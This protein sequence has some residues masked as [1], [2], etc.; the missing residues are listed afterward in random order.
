MNSI[1]SI[2]FRRFKKKTLLL[3]RKV[4]SNCLDI[5]NNLC[6]IR[7]KKLFQCISQVYL[8][9]DS[10]INILTGNIGIVVTIIKL[11]P[12]QIATGS[13]DSSIRLWNLQT[14]NCY[15]ELLGHTTIVQCI[16]KL[17]S[18]QIASGSCTIRI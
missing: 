14:G 3:I 7:N 8:T 16:I 13:C 4:L 11:N 10:N 6:K 18:A 9:E 1:K 12:N 5:C 17:K 15:C 2:K